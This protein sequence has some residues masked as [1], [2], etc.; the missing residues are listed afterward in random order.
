VA[1]EDV[2]AGTLLMASKAYATGSSGP[3]DR[4]PL[5]FNFL[6]DGVKRP[7]F[8]STGVCIHAI[9]RE[10]RRNPQ[11]ASELYALYAGDEG[12]VGDG[13]P[14]GGVIDV[15]RIQRICHYNAFGSGSLPGRDSPWRKSAS[16]TELWLMPSFLNHSCLG[17]L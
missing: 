10:L 3:Q 1:T 5:S 7:D 8:T 4:H 16:T 12:E 2:K 17:R 13:L 15:G 6:A 14:A 11:T 9:V